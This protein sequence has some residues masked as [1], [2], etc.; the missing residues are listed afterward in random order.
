MITLDDTNQ[1]FVACV[2]SLCIAILR[3]RMTDPKVC[4]ANRNRAIEIHRMAVKAR[5]IVKGK[6]EVNN[7][8]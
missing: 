8:R 1:E 5:G 6:S 2:F 4:E 7:E 3:I